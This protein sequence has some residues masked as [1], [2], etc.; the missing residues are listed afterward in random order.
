ME[1]YYVNIKFKYTLLLFL[2]FP[3]L[4][5][6]VPSSSS[7]NS[8]NDITNYKISLN[9]GYNVVKYSAS[10]NQNNSQFT[11]FTSYLSNNYIYL[12]NSTITN[13]IGQISV[14]QS[15]SVTSLINSTIWDFNYIISNNNKFLV[16]TSQLSRNWYIN[17]FDISN[18][19]NNFTISSTTHAYFIANIITLP[20]TPDVFFSFYNSTMLLLV[21]YSFQTDSFS[22]FYTTPNLS[23]DYTITN[24]N[25][26]TLGNNIYAAIAYGIESYTPPMYNE[27]NIYVLNNLGLNYT[28]DFPSI[29]ISTFTVFSGGFLFNSA[30]NN[31][32]YQYSAS[33]NTLRSIQSP[34]STNDPNTRLSSYDNSS[35][36]VLDQN[37]FALDEIIKNSVFIQLTY[38]SVQN[39]NYPNDQNSLQ[40]VNLG[41]NKFYLFYGLLNTGQDEIIFN[42]IDMPPNVFLIP[43][44]TFSSPN[45]TYS[46]VTGSVF[47]VIIILFL[48]LIFLVAIIPITLFITLSLRKKSYNNPK[49]INYLNPIKNKLKFCSN[50]GTKSDPEDVY[51]ENCGEKL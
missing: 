18:F 49:Y 41:S 23:P 21:R 1:E 14:E 36:L 15:I 40:A 17:F 6:S 13:S 11:I 3:S 35:F 43:K 9:S 24:V 26:F 5:Y 25:I 37:G 45:S 27:S 46:S 31:T 19:N 29:L 48:I 10:L 39:N 7:N 51:C 38:Y 4:I 50:C 44:N 20:T 34:S 22:I 30:T 28:K 8:T 2:I 42:R 16:I 32:F 12:S 47:P 33:N